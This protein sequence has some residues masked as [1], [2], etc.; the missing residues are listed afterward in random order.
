M[1]EIGVAALVAWL[2]GAAW[3]SVFAKV[4]ISASG[5][6]LDENG[7]PSNRRDPIPY[8]LSLVALL[9]VSAMMRY[10]LSMLE[11]ATLQKGF[12]GGLGVGLFFISP[13]IFINN[14]YSGRPLNLSLIDGGYASIGCA[15]IGLVVTVL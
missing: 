8:I 1:L 10:G 3:Y 12:L 5:V 9:V 11:V 14:G 4:W 15:L 2:F 7:V 6:A 13:W